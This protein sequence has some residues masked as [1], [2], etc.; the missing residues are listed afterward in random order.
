M[1]PNILRF[2]MMESEGVSFFKKPLLYCNYFIFFLENKYSNFVLG[3]SEETP[4]YK[5]LFKQ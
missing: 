4:F 5:R 3:S 2:P 1:R